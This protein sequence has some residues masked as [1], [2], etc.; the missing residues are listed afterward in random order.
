MFMATGKN[1][2]FLS[3]HM[4]QILSISVEI[5]FYPGFRLYLSGKTGPQSNRDDLCFLL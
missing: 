4:H 2:S 5:P 3:T 1:W